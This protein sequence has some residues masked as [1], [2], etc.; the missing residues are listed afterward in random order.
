MAIHDKEG[1]G[2]GVD[3]PIEGCVTVSSNTSDLR[4]HMRAAHRAEDQHQEGEGVASSQLDFVALLS[5]VGEEVIT[6]ELG[7]EEGLLQL[8]Q[9]ESENVEVVDVGEWTA[10]QGEPDANLISA[11]LVT[12]DTNAISPGTGSVGG[13]GADGLVRKRRASSQSG[14]GGKAAKSSCSRESTINLQDLE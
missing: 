4:S 1:E 6:A 12:L 14:R 3:C 11:G 8:V 13:D 7:A 5:S 2:K 9:V 10:L